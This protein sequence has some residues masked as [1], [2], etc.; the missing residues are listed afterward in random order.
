LLND[1]IKK[2]NGIQAAFDN[3]PDGSA[4][5]KAVGEKLE[6][7]KKQIE[8]LKDMDE[9][10]KALNNKG[11][12]HYRVFIPHGKYKVELFTTQIPVAKPV[13]VKEANQNSAAKS[14]PEQQQPTKP[15][16]KPAKKKP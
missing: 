13:E 10:Y 15:S 2:L 12:I 8:F 1:F 3:S 6:Q 4:R 11:K 14:E 9:L 5:K 16:K 7:L